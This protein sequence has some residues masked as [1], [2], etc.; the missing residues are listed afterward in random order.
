M[1][2]LVF[3]WGV[4]FP[5]IKGAFAE[6]PPFAFNGLRFAIAA[7]LLLTV[8]WKQKGSGLI[9]GADLPGLV[10]LGLIGHAGYQT[11]FITG[12]ARTSAGHSA[13][14]L[15][16][17]PLLVGVLGVAMRIERPTARM[18]IGL[19][20][21]FL[22][23]VVLIRGRGGATV[24]SA[25]VV[26][27]MLTLAG[28]VCWAAYTVMSR[29]WLARYSA[30]HL[31]TVTLVFGL[32]VIFGTA[33]PEA[34]HLAW[35]AISLRAWAALAFSAVFAVALSY[36]IWY[37]SVQVVGSARTAAFSNLIPVV[38]LLSA[39]VMLGEPLGPA[40]VGGTAIVL[41]GVWLARTDPARTSHVRPRA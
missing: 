31:T 7:V 15:S 22:G 9:R 37:S 17:V 19:V 28:A 1:G 20:L 36:L 11:M 3:I 35:G 39:W 34:A 10:L 23:V 16:M 21:A 8:L 30:L 32:P 38:A 25:T 5:I 27:D 33:L 14:I 29:P 40:Q 26:G 2:L 4:N 12:L 13:I 41:S 24:Q 18:W 6:I